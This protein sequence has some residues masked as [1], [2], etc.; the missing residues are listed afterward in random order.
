MTAIERNLYAVIDSILN[1][2]PPSEDMLVLSLKKC[3][4]TAMYAAPDSYAPWEKTAK[5]LA[6]HIGNPS[7]P[8]H[9]QV[10]DCFSG[11]ASES[12]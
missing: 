11:A 12:T 1:I 5:V 8:W 9:Q 3:Q 10:L 4:D 6:S 7:E 2:C